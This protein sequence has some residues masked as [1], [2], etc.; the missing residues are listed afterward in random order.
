MQHSHQLLDPMVAGSYRLVMNNIE[1]RDKD[2]QILQLKNE[3]DQMEQERDYYRGKYL[4][5]Q[6]RLRDNANYTAF[7]V[8]KIKEE[9]YQLENKYHNAKK[10]YFTW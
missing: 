1:L 7:T 10:K 6:K 3:L 8:D 2:T 5:L 4:T 9:Y